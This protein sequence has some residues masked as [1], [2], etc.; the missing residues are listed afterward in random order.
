M[1]KEFLYKRELET[2]ETVGI[3]STAGR[4]GNASKFYAPAHLNLV[5]ME[6]G[7]EYRSSRSKGVLLIESVEYN[8]FAS[9]GDQSHFAKSLE[10]LTQKADQVKSRVE[11]QREHL[12]KSLTQIPTPAQVGAS[13]GQGDLARQNQRRL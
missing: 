3:V 11:K 7:A 12:E 9:K 13:V 1:A 4:G 10:T 5:L 8:A 2:G 6:K